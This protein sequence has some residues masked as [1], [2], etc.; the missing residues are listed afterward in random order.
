MLSC[1]QFTRRRDYPADLPNEMAD[2][3]DDVVGH[4]ARPDIF[5][6]TVDE[7][8]KPPVV[9]LAPRDPA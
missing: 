5:R 8:P 4:Y 3:P 2:G 9:S 7:A 1:N 6:L